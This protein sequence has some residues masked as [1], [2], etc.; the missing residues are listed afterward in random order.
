MGEALAPEKESHVG[1]AGLEAVSPGAVVDKGPQRS[2]PGRWQ[3]RDAHSWPM[4]QSTGWRA[5][6]LAGSSGGPMGSTLSP[7]LRLVRPVYPLESGS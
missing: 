4:S 2:T 6:T 7:V 1:C 3:E 5:R